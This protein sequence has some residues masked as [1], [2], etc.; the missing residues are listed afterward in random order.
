LRLADDLAPSHGSRM[1]YPCCC[2]GAGGRQG[3]RGRS[4]N[5]GKQIQKVPGKGRWMSTGADPQKG[6]EKSPRKEPPGAPSIRSVA[7]AGWQSDHQGR[8]LGRRRRPVVPTGLRDEVQQ[9][10][11]C[12]AKT[13]CGVRP[14]VHQGIG[15]EQTGF[16]SGFHHE[17]PGVPCHRPTQQPGRRRM[18]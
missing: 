13:Q 10:R 16:P 7:G 11:A 3:R 14:G 5:N 9:P 12:R 17:D 1:V 8:R 15:G 2:R 18:R 6:G 4:T